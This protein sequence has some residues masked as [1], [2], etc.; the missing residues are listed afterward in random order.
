[1]NCLI[2]IRQRYPAAGGRATKSLPILFW[3]SRIKPGISAR[4]SWRAKPGVSQSSVVKFAQKLG[5]KGFPA[6]KT[7]A[8][9]SAGQQPGSALRAGT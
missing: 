4:S 2:R 5:F 7:G 3:L 6:L 9:R 8:Q 1:M